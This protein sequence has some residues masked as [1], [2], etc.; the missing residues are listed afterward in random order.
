M[1]LNTLAG[2]SYKDFSQY[3]S[4]L[5]VGAGR[6]GEGGLGSGSAW[7]LPQPLSTDRPPNACEDRRARLSL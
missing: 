2:R 3:E 6:V 5:A 4:G 7:L 1:P